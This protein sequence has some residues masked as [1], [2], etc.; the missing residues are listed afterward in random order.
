MD[1]D[2]QEERR[3]VD[4]WVAGWSPRAA[5]CLAGPRNASEPGDEDWPSAENCPSASESQ[6]PDPWHE[7]LKAIKVLV[8]LCSEV[9]L[10][11]RVARERVYPMLCIVGDRLAGGRPAPMGDAEVML[12]GF[13]PCLQDLLDFLEQMDLVVA[14]L[15]AHV[16]EIYGDGSVV[17][18]RSVMYR[19]FE[20]AGAGLLVLWTAQ[21]VVALKILPLFFTYRRML[22][23]MMSK[24]DRHAQDL[25]VLEDV[26]GQVVKME[27]ALRMGPYTTFIDTHVK[28]GAAADLLKSKRFGHVID[29]YL[30]DATAGLLERLDTYAEMPAD[31]GLL[32]SSL[33]LFVTCSWGCPGLRDRKLV[34]QLAEVQQKAPILPL[35]CNLVVNPAR[36]LLDMLPP[37]FLPLLPRDYARQAAGHSA[38]YLA[39]VSESMK[40]SLEAAAFKGAVWSAELA[41][42]R[43]SMKTPIRVRWLARLQ[44]VVVEGLQLLTRLKSLLQTVIQLHVEQQEPLSKGGL[45]CVADCICMLK[46]VAATLRQFG[47]VIEPRIPD[48]MG[49]TKAQLVE[50]LAKT[51]K[52]VTR[53]EKNK[54]PLMGVGTMR[55]L[56]VM[57]HKRDS[58]S[59]AVGAWLISQAMEVAESD[60]CSPQMLSLR[61]TFDAL[62]GVSVVEE[63]A[64]AGM[65]HLLDELDCLSAY[66]QQVEVL[67]KCEFLYF[68]PELVRNIL[69]DMLWNS[70]RAAQLGQLV[71]SFLDVRHLLDSTGFNAS[72]KDLE[73]ELSAMVRTH[74]LDPLCEAVEM[75]LHQQARVLGTKDGDPMPQNMG[76]LRNLSPIME[77]TTLKVGESEVDIKHYVSESL[78]RKM[79]SWL[80]HGSVDWQTIG[81]I[82]NLAASKYGVKVATVEAQEAVFSAELDKLSTVEGVRRFAD[83]YSL[84]LHSLAFVKLTPMPLGTLAD[85]PEHVDVSQ[86]VELIKAD[87]LDIG[88]EALRCVEKDLDRRDES[89]DSAGVGTDNGGDVREDDAAMALSTGDGVVEQEDVSAVRRVSSEADAVGL[90]VAVAEASTSMGPKSPS[91]QVEVCEGSEIFDLQLQSPGPSDWTYLREAR[92]ISP[93]ESADSQDSGQEGGGPAKPPTA[94]QLR[95]SSALR[96]MT[97]FLSTKLKDLA[98]LCLAAEARSIIS[99]TTQRWHNSKKAVGNQYPVAQ[100]ELVRKEVLALL[101]AGTLSMNPLQAIRFELVSVGRAVAL[102]MILCQGMAHF[103]ERARSLLPRAI[104]RSFK[105]FHDCLSQVQAPEEVL[106]QGLTFDRSMGPFS[107][108]TPGHTRYLG[109]LRRAFVA[110]L[111]DNMLSGM[112]SLFVL[113]PALTLDHVDVMRSVKAQQ[114]GIGHSDVVGFADESFALGLSYVVSMLGQR[115]AFDSLH[116]FS[117][118]QRHLHQRRVRLLATSDAGSV[119]RRAGAPRNQRDA[120]AQRAA[121][122]IEGVWGT[123]QELRLLEHTMLC[124]W[125]LFDYR[126][127]QGGD[128]GDR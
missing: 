43:Q 67:G 75:D 87:M 19:A 29:F 111:D 45:W 92:E 117:S 21:T 69:D 98:N 9:Q 17:M 54:A 55:Y 116:W 124:A 112:Q 126:G 109:L 107:R 37:S 26:Q 96:S 77:L 50:Q 113:V 128:G 84:Q 94:R 73:L 68:H 33:V 127:G 38:A 7:S 62:S 16:G 34:R 15:L 82:R 123:M 101:K 74:L 60:L 44:G 106:A 90:G 20:A 121:K 24:A 110:A 118:S 104:V 119:P 49:Q 12:A 18:R 23:T 27:E 83:T 28:Q 95:V 14:Q 99:Q 102:I 79:R 32:L 108:L 25:G 47:D 52:K 114:Q 115:E 3:L 100:A 93:H 85:T 64:M 76:E 10:L 61:L 80:S 8:V 122:V 35:H 66:S 46:S 1:V 11:E 103:G 57:N 30:R 31:R 71:G 4:A 13:L 88:P 51:L 120:E 22:H 63:P 39:E 42:L 72:A 70:H 86:F 89:G 65:R 48:I 2:L 41:A 58:E 105:T 91:P 53:L 97:Q 59:R 5:A 40:E 125:V 78:Q 81:L 36:F 6:G 56:G